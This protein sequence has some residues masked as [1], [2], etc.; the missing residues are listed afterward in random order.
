MECVFTLVAFG[1]GFLVAQLWKMVSGLVSGKKVSAKEAIRQFSRSGGMPSGHTAS[2]TAATIY[3][4]CVNGFGSSLFA[5]ALCI[6]MIVIYDATHVRYAVGKQ[7]RALNELL[8]QDA[9]AEL[10]LVEGHTIPQ[11]MVGAVI[12]VIIGLGM[13]GLTGVL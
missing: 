12:G 2:M 1:L 13:A 10:P 5:L 4:G 3:L 11:V 7:G 9:K 8:T 6:W